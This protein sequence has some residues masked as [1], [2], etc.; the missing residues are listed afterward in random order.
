MHWTSR[1]IVFEYH[2]KHSI[3][4]SVID[5]AIDT[6]ATMK[7]RAHDE[8]PPSEVKTAATDRKVWYAPN[9]FDA[10]DEEEMMA[11]LSCLRDGWLA[12]GPLTEK[13][14]KT[15]S[16]YFGKKFG[17]MVN[18]GSSANLLALAALELQPG[19]EVITP[20]LTFST[21]IA[22]IFQVGGTPI[23]ID[24]E[25]DTF[26]PTIEC[27]AKAITP[28]TRVILLPNLMGSK[29]DW[30]AVKEMIHGKMRRMDI[31]LLEDSCDTMTHTLASDVSTISFYASHVIT[32]GGGG[33]MVMVNDEKLL[34]KCLMY[35]DWG[36]IGSNSEEM[37]E[38]FEHSLDGLEYDFKFFFGV[39]GYNLRAVEMNAAFGLVQMDKLNGFLSIRK[40]NL[41]RYVERLKGSTFILPRNAEDFNWLALPL[42]HPKRKDVCFHLESHGVQTR[43]CMA[44][45]ISRHP[46][47][48][49]LKKEFP[50]A[51]EVMGNGFMIGLHHGLSL[52]DIDY[53][54]DLLGDF[55]RRSKE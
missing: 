26:V 41:L 39:Q 45:N 40:R 48:A 21:T 13:F 50:E 38:R 6:L 36:R 2:S 9:M 7:T 15:V 54:C 24:V 55:E 14:E 43:L 49:H 10:F 29:P 47:F 19:D 16:A 30:D 4:Q 44:G 25:R 35:R 20:A 33:G 34:E 11:V 5:T 53:V 8:I 3:S 12:P 18:S 52:E 51:D 17:I 42:L 1:E 37:E 32:A 22:P 31:V 23:L 27:I 46:G 28:K